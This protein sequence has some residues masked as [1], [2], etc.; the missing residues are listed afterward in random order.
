[1]AGAAT[2]VLYAIASVARFARMHAGIDLAIFTEAV[3][4]YSQGRAPWSY[5]KGAWG[6]N[7]LGEHFS[8][9]V[10]IIAPLY[11]LIPDARVLLVVQAALVGVSVTV[12]TR[13]AVRMVGPSA[14]LAIGVSYALAWGVQSMALFDFHE[15]AFALPLLA[16]ALSELARGRDGRAIAWAVP[17]MVVKEDSVF[18][19]LGIALVLAARRR[20]RPAAGLAGVALVSFGLIVGMVIP[21]VGFYGR[22]T[23]WSAS[24]TSGGLGTAVA[25]FVSSVTSGKLVVLAVFLLAPSLGLAVRSP[26]ALV[27]LPAL[28]SR[29]TSPNET[30]WGTGLHYNATV[31]LVLAFAACDGLRR[32]RERGRVADLR[33]VRGAWWCAAGVLLIGWWCPLGGLSRELTHPCPDCA[34]KQMALDRIPDGVSVA[35]DDTLAAYLVDRTFVHELKPGLKDTS[36][37][38]VYPLFIALDRSKSGIWAHPQVWDDWREQIAG[39]GRFGSTYH[40]IGEYLRAD[41]VDGVNHVVYDVMILTTDYPSSP[42]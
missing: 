39:D 41:D 38:P 28:A 30:Y 32:I 23:Y 10:A 25:S 27:A 13:S 31:T 40:Y 5:L 16:M 3:K 17:L 37:R 42:R 7:L 12:L 8:P 15:V 19:L 35:A 33:L 36:G 26:M 29:F 6:F 14:G 2:F 11:R 1:M 18:L 22:Y 20:W 9:V 34:Q 24:G 21:A 4:Q